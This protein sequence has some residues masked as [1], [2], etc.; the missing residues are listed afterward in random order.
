[1]ISV[2][3]PL[4]AKASQ[5]TN[6]FT[7]LQD[8]EPLSFVGLELTVDTDDC[9]NALSVLSE[10]ISFIEM[11]GMAGLS[12]YGRILSKDNVNNLL[13]LALYAKRCRHKENPPLMQEEKSAVERVLAKTCLT[14]LD[15]VAIRTVATILPG[16]GLAY[17]GAKKSTSLRSTLNQ[18]GESWLELLDNSN[19]IA[20]TLKKSKGHLA[21]TYGFLLTTFNDAISMPLAS[22]LIT[23]E[24]LLNF[25]S[26]TTTQQKLAIY[27]GELFL[28]I[29]LGKNLVDRSEKTLK[30]TGLAG[31]APNLS[32][33][34]FSFLIDYLSELNNQQHLSS[35]EAHLLYWLRNNKKALL[36]SLEKIQESSTPT[37]RW[38]KTRYGSHH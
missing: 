27:L 35:K 36:L 1:M 21:N 29:P 14:A 10:H 4:S 20:T 8:I 17:I 9:L 38:W 34:E 3:T 25:L 26:E 7:P 16:G 11:F 12:F 24:A 15:I 23:K 6:L 2:L 18:L 22:Y 30:A 19:A 5:E 33:E 37:S 31:K 32:T 13:L 28:E